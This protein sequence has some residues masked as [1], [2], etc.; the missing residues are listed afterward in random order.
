MC[1]RS[2]SS[3]EMRNV[4]KASPA[5]EASPVSGG[6]SSRRGRRSDP[7]LSTEPDESTTARSRTFCSSRMLPGQGY[8]TRRS[9]VSRATASIGRPNFLAKRKRKYVTSSGYLPCVPEGAGPSAARRS[10]G[11]TD[12]Q[13]KR[14]ARTSLDRSRL[15]AVMMRTSTR[16]VLLLPTAL[17]FRSCRTRSSF[18]WGVERQFADFVEEQRS[19]I[20]EL[21]AAHPPLNRL[22]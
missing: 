20:R 14:H 12:R 7:S 10:G 1:R 5:L 4:G 16:T 11:R 18:T 15:V 8:L 21:E 13:R 2:A 3:S 19:A 17:E 22:L 9:I 6:V